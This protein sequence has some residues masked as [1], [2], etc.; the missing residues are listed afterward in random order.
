MTNDSTTMILISALLLTALLNQSF[1]EYNHS[2]NQNSLLAKRQNDI[3][4]T[5]TVT[6]SISP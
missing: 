2:Q 6:G 5:G 1:R 4:S 3:L